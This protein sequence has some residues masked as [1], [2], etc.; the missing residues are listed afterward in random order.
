M[1]EAIAIVV[2]NHIAQGDPVVIEGDGILPDI[3]DHPD[4]HTFVETGHLCAVFVM[5]ESADELLRSMLTRG[6]GFTSSGATPQA[7]R[8]AEMNWL[9]SQWLE[10]EALRRG[11]PIV[12]TQPWETLEVRILDSLSENRSEPGCEGG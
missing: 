9:Y 3:I 1:T 12:R 8:M 6:R 10:R 7:R 11:I 4:L 2:G 5:P